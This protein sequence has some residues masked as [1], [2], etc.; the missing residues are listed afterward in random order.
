MSTALS[1][2]RRSLSSEGSAA[3]AAI[4]TTLTGPRPF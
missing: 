1:P 2:E 4:P 3:P